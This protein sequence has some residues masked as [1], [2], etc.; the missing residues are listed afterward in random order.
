VNSHPNIP[1]FE[2]EEA[3]ANNKYPDRHNQLAAAAN[4]KKIVF[5]KKRD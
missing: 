2:K 3:G 4:R 5:K 1:F